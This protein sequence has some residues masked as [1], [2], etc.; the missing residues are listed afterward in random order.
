[1]ETHSHTIKTVVS[2]PAAILLLVRVATAESASI[3][4]FS[5]LVLP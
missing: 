4:N 2:M 3:L 5:R 1:M